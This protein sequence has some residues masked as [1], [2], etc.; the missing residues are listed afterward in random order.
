MRLF[1][2]VG[3]PAPIV[4][5][6]EALPRPE[7][8]QLRWTTP[9][10]WHITLRFLGEVD[11]VAEVADAVNGLAGRFDPGAIE[12]RLGPESRWFPGRR[13]LQV[14]VAGLD[15]LAGLVRDLTARWGA[16]DQPGFSGH[17]TLARVR[18]RGGGPA[19]LAGVPV[20][21]RFAVARV[22]VF[23]STLGA[24]NASYEVLA[25]VPIVRAR[26]A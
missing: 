14:P 6:V 9:A 8:R 16:A 10:Q 12:A 23:A 1:V 15:A 26:P 4:E 25:D 19:H 7:T 17:V 2:A 20:E 18:G 24:G 13:V 21:G 11:E 22:S 3:L 5:L